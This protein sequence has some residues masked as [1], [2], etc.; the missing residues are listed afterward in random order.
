M[1]GFHQKE[2]KLSATLTYAR[3]TDTSGAI[4][5]QGANGV[6]IT[7]TVKGTNATSG[8]YT[9]IQSFEEG[10]PVPSGL[11][12][13]IYTS[14][15][16]LQHEGEIELVGSEIPAGFAMGQK[17]SL[18][19]L[20]S[21]F[22]SMMVQQIT[23]EPFAGRITLRVG[24]PRQIGI[25]DLIELMRANRYRI[26]YNLPIQQQGSPE[27]SGNVPLGS[28]MPK[29]DS[30]ADSTPSS[31]FGVS[32]DQGG[33]TTA[34][35]VKDAIGPAANPGPQVRIVYYDSAGAKVTTQP[36]ATMNVSDLVALGL[37][38]H[39]A[40]FVLLKFKDPNNSCAPMKMA[41]MGTTPEPDV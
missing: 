37:V 5:I 11:A 18:N 15:A 8:T 34:V 20:A 7:C 39:D 32:K 14:R 31:A 2:V 10:D 26:I 33:G 21:S 28:N 9:A 25:Q 22:G 16:T 24:P 6:P 38:N 27:A 3:T 36:S 40:K 4:P 17:I 1:T 29:Q 23:E 19:G 30:V 41:V 13:D 35:V 12:Q